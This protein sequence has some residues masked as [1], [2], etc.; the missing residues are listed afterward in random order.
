MQL[1]YKVLPGAATR[2]DGTRI[3]VAITGFFAVDGFIFASWAVRIPA[4]KAA[5]GASPEALG[6][7]LLGA[8]AGAIA[9]MTLT[10]A[11]C[12]RFGSARVVVLGGVWLSLALL[13][14]AL[15]RS[16]PALGAALVVFG[17][18]YGGLNVAM[19]SLAIDLVAALRRPIM[20]SFHAAW[21][22]GG[23]AG[24]ALGGLAAPLLT[25]LA[26][27]SLVCLLGL[28]VTTACGRI[29]LTSPVPAARPAPRAA[30]DD[31]AGPAAAG[32]TVTTGAP[33]TTGT[34]ARQDHP[35]RARTA[36][37]D[38]S[39]PSPDTPGC[40]GRCCCSA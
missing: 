11:L 31:A 10:G 28:A 39:H 19:N 29:V 32:T 34:P 40:G 26:H 36:A 16:A 21:S 15:A 23:L 37:A 30:A 8:S 35:A 2:H 5:V 18:G 33:A 1:L 13:L 17:I 9:T 20:P 38:A 22:F 12:R 25:P 6:V 27:F 14:P 7:A 4:V 24:S 3:R